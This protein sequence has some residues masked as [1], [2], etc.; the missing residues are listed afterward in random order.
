MAGQLLALPNDCVP[1]LLSLKNIICSPTSLVA[2]EDVGAGVTN[3]LWLTVESS[4]WGG[5]E[6]DVAEHASG[7]D[8][9]EMPWPRSTRVRGCVS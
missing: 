9:E 5:T 6:P 2:E 3:V 4:P 8:S 1:A 7:A